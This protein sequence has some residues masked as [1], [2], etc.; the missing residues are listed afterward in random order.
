MSKEERRSWH[1]PVLWKAALH[2]SCIWLQA[3]LAIGF[4]TALSRPGPSMFIL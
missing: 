2:L 3:A 1:H 4:Y